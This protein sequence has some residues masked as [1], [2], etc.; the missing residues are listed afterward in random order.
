MS[1]QNDTHPEDIFIDR[2]MPGANDTEREYARENVRRLI[3]VLVRISYRIGRER[4][5]RESSSWCRFEEP[6]AEPA[7]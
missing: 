5:S 6:D 3:A 7:L 2:Y 1:E 4:D